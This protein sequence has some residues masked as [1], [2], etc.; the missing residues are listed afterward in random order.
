ML[1]DEKAKEARALV[2]RLIEL[3]GDNPDREGLVDTPDRV[4]RSWSE[5]YAGYRDN[6]RQ[7]DRSFASENDQVVLLRGID[8][9]STCEHHMLP[10]FGKAAIAYLPRDGRVLG[11][12]KLVRILNA[13]ARR[14]QIQERLTQE[15]ANAIEAAVAPL[16]VVVVI[17][18]VHLCMVGRGV[19]QHETSM[20]TS[21]VTG[22]FRED[23]KARAEV[24]GLIRGAGNPR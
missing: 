5:L 19:R 6:G 11:V 4:V 21:R 22:L 16:G 17:N 14:L 3:V 7:Y 2:R 20:V 24:M 13:K 12:S 9:Y 18:A 15:V 1:S 8:V 10:F 23:E